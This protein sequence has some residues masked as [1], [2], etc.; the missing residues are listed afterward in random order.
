MISAKVFWGVLTFLTLVIW[1]GVPFLREP[2]EELDPLMRSSERFEDLYQAIGDSSITPDSAEHAFKVLFLDLKRHTSSFEK[3]CREDLARS[4]YVFPVRGY[5]PKSS[6]GGRGRGYKPNGFDFFD[7]RIR[8]SHPAH[9][10]FIRDR[11]NDAIDDVMCEPVDVLAFTGGF[12][13]GT[14]EDWSP[15]SQWRGGNYIWVYNPCLDALLYYAHNSTVDVRPGQWIKAGDVL[16]KMGRTG[17]NAQQARSTT[18]LHFMYLKITEEGLPEPF[19]P[20][21]EL[22]NSTV[23]DWE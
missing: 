12:V 11:D 21:G 17:F 10:L 22:M 13:L 8:K 9:D 18:H 2:A 23:L 4:G 16:G 7:A 5:S 19:N 14:K 15:E 3:E 20:L 1:Q 6:I